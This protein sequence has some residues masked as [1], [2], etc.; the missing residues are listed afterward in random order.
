MLSTE[1][2]SGESVNKDVGH[3]KHKKAEN[4][5]HLRAQSSILDLSSISC[6]FGGLSSI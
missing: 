2:G 5:M 6:S 4:H 3:R 1:L